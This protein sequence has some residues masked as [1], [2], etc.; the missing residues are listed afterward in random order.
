MII[1][2]FADSPIQKQMVA[3][4]E[5][6]HDILSQ[7]AATGC[8]NSIAAS[9]SDC[10]SNNTQHTDSA[11][12]FIGTNGFLGIAS[13]GVR[14][15]DSVVQFWKSATSAIVRRRDSRTSEHG[16][17]SVVGRS[18]IVKEGYSHDWDIPQDK[19]GFLVKDN[20][21]VKL[22]MDI[23]TLTVLTLNSLSLEESG[24]GQTDYPRHLSREKTRAAQ[25][26]SSWRQALL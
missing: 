22:H 21:L 8:I 10:R 17:Y 7:E 3:L 24:S 19:A 26:N 23:N 5:R 13:P 20:S 1:Q 25:G 9:R 12:L 11:R 16:E 18:S 15:G 4:C 6:L 14:S 2:K